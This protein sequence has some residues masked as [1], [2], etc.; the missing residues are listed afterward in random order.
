MQKKI[1]VNFKGLKKTRETIN[2]PFFKGQIDVYVLPSGQKIKSSVINVKPY[3]KRKIRIFYWMRGYTV[4]PEKIKNSYGHPPQL[5]AEIRDINNRRLK[6][7]MSHNGAVGEF[8]WH[9]YYLD[10]KIPSSGEKLYLYI[11]N[12]HGSRAWF[13]RFSLELIDKSNSYSQ[14]EK[15]DPV[16]GSLAA[17]PEYEP[18]NFHFFQKPPATK[19]RWKFMFGLKAGLKRQ[20]YDITTISDLKRYY[21]ESVKNDLDQMNHGIMYFPLRSH[22]GKVAGV[23]PKLPQDW[24]KELAKLIIND[25]DSTT[26]YWGTKHYPQSMSVTYHYVEMFFNLGIERCDLSDKAD[27]RRCIAEKIPR[28]EKIVET[29]LKLQTST[30]CRGERLLTAW[31]Q[32]AYNFCI[33]PNSG[34]SHCHLGTTLNAILLMRRCYRFVSYETKKKIDHSIKSALKYVLQNC[35]TPKGVWKQHDTDSSP[36]TS[37]FFMNILDSSRY[38][39]TRTSN[40]VH[41]PELNIYKTNDLIIN[42]RNWRTGQNSFRIY[43]VTKR[44]KPTPKNIIGIISRGDK[45]IIDLD[46]YLAVLKCAK[47]AKDVWN[48]KISNRKYYGKKIS[49][50]SKHL[51]TA[52]GYKKLIIPE[53]TLPAKPFRIVA[54]AVDWYGVESTMVELV[55]DK[56]IG[57]E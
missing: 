27:P 26:G 39:E 23:L 42:C 50:L 57:T 15:Q 8:P 45:R 29:T 3:K 2:N 41:L 20:P 11:R 43:A 16:T 9:C 37:M 5:I 10:I 55:F 28:A 35:V 46:P 54:V 21:N 40:I 13:G 38:L 49:E 14:N 1:K 32:K 48:F 52:S 25:Q 30:T 36:S 18:I 6:N 53:S 56:K 7:L 24:Y 33:N 34:K 19:Y 44:D 17:F 51:P 31:S 12:R 4:S 22:Q 47:A